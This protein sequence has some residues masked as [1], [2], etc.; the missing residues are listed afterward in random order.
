MLRILSKVIL[1]IPILLLCEQLFGLDMNKV[2]QEKSAVQSSE[3][4][5]ESVSKER[6]TTDL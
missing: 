1:A 4:I 6:L 3:I 2:V 5:V